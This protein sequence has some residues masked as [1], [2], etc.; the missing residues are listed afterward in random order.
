M[1]G[2]RE[3]LISV[4]DR[5]T[6]TSKSLLE[7]KNPSRRIEPLER[8]AKK[9]FRVVVRRLLYRSEV[10]RSSHSLSECVPADPHLPFNLRV[11]MSSH[12]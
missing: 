6:G 2:I 10:K 8:K 11:P 3:R 5:L 4:G 7:E 12:N 1:D 9:G